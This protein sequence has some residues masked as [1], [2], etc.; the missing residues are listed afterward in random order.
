MHKT[1]SDAEKA[2]IRANAGKIKDEEIRKKLVEMRGRQI[3]LQSLRKQRQKLGIYKVSGRGKCSIKGENNDNTNGLAD[4]Q[5]L[6]PSS[7]L[8]SNTGGS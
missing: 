6:P 1:W 5:Q 4:N 8:V 3:S 2:Y 7:E